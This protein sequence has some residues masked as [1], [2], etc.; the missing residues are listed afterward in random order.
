VGRFA[1]AQFGHKVSNTEVAIITDAVVKTWSLKWEIAL[2]AFV[3]DFLKSL[4]VA[5]H[6]VREGRCPVC[7][8]AA[9][10]AQPKL[11]A[12]DHGLCLVVQY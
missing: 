2:G 3:D 8:A 10:E 5:L 12:L 4:M 1:V 6:E 9:A 11:D 7:M